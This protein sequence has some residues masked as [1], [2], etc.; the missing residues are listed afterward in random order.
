MFCGCE[1]LFKLDLSGFD[2]SGVTTMADMFS[3]CRSLVELNLAG[4][5]VSNVT[6]MREMFR[7][8]GSLE[9]LG[10][11]PAAFGHGDT[12]D[13]YSKCDRLAGR[14]DA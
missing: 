13:M 7:S 9:T 3:G 1:S 8:C 4:W 11:D 5:D 10:R 12:T 6:D 14:P 2:T